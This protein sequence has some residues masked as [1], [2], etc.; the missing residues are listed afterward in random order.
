MKLTAKQAELW[1]LAEEEM[2]K[3][4]EAA[5]HPIRG[6]MG[7]LATITRNKDKA[8]RDLAKKEGTREWAL[9]QSQS[10]ASPLMDSTMNDEFCQKLIDIIN[11]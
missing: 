9:C 11:A 7:G 2:T 8:I 10:L 6:F 3:I 1:K 5:N 4:A